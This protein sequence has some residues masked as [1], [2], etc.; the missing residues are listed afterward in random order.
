MIFYCVGL[1]KKTVDTTKAAAADDEKE[2]EGAAGAAK[3]A[4][5]R[6]KV[7]PDKDV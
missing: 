3:L 2:A 4:H 5:S 1:S 6:P 7:K